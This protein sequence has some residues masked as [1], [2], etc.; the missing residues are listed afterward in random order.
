MSEQLGTATGRPTA[1][2]DGSVADADAAEAGSDTGLGVGPACATL[3]CYA[4]LNEYLPEQWRRRDIPVRFKP[5][6]TVAALLDKLDIPPSAVELVLL[7]GQSAG[8]EATVDEGARVSLYPVFEAFD[9]APLLRVHDGPLREPR[10]VCDAHLGKLGRRLRLLGFDTVLAQDATG[11]DPGDDALVQLAHDEHRI[12]LTRDRGLLERPGLTHALE[13]PQVPVDTQL[14]GLIQRLQLQRA[15]A[16]FT[17]CT[18]CN[19]PLEP[20]DPA[21]L[22]ELPS[23]VLAH[24][25][26]FWR[27]PGCGRSYWEG[28]HHRRMSRLVQQLLRD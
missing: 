13:V 19:T 25:D 7:D 20:A 27:C 2:T 26:R 11:E 12:L 28:S 3:R 22:R 24:Q 15:A 5:P 10:F 9:V 21:D 8:L 18:C 17:R 4:E 23:G 1:S 14:R 6:L 16:P